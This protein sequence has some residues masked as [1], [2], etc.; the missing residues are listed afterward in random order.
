MFTGDV[1][2]K[3]LFL[4]EVALNY[5]NKKT[6]ATQNQLSIF[7]NNEMLNLYEEVL[8]KKDLYNFTT[9]EL[10][11]FLKAL[12]KPNKQTL[13]TEFSLMNKYLLYA[14]KEKVSKFN[15]N[16]AFAISKNDFD[17][18]IQED[19]EREK[20]F[21]KKQLK[22]V[23]NRRESNTEYVIPLYQD[24]AIYILIY[25]GILGKELHDLATF[26]KEDFSYIKKCLYFKGEVINLEDWE[27]DI[28]QNAIDEKEY[29]EENKSKNKEYYKFID[30]PFLLKRK[31][32]RDGGKTPLTVQ[33]INKRIKDC[34][35]KLGTDRWSATNIYTSG[36]VNRIL[37]TNEHWMG[38]KDRWTHAELDKYL[39]VHSIPL[40]HQRVM[41][42]MNILRDKIEAEK[43]V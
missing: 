9:E 11:K 37:T 10:K 18:L 23:L 21:T 29:F 31:Q 39:R 38:I 17:E 28:L 24:K 36:V 32:N 27:S 6:N 19:K 22:E 33:M 25:N 41:R 8:F 14:I 42:V 4:E 13:A 5:N 1:K 12:N 26:K 35:L 16:Q 43:N 30:S 20:Y 15:T 40:S 34:N 2:F 7:L 3:E